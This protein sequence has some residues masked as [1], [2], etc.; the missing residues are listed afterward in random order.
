M[1]YNDKL[2]FLAPDAAPYSDDWL[3]ARAH[4]LRARWSEKGVCF[5]MGVTQHK[6]RDF[7]WARWYAEKQ[8]CEFFRGGR[9]TKRVPHVPTDGI[10]MDAAETVAFLRADK[11]AGHVLYYIAQCK[12]R[13]EI[14]ANVRLRNPDMADAM[15]AKYRQSPYGRMYDMYGD[16]SAEAIADALDPDWALA[17]FLGEEYVPREGGVIPEVSEPVAAKKP[18]RKKA[19][20]PAAVEPL[21]LDFSFDLQREAA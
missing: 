1:P 15:L 14:V 16:I 4:R 17:A 21:V 13:D 6:D 11:S 2:Q 8:W 20:E 19:P 5:G 3:L 12:S 9:D 18:R 7:Q 10:L